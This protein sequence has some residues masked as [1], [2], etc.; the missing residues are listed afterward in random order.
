MNTIQV[1]HG[2]LNRRFEKVTDEAFAFLF[3]GNVDE[4]PT[5]V[6]GRK[7]SLS[8]NLEFVKV[9]L[10]R[11]RRSGGSSFFESQ[12]AS[13]ATSKIDTTLINISGKC[14]FHFNL[15]YSPNRELLFQ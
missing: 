5:S 2:F 4:E 8:I 10:S 15:I 11:I 13:K 6:T 1:Y 7:D 12:S 9:S 3:L 14:L